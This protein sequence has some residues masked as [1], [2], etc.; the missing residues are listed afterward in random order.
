M[1]SLSAVLLLAY[2]FWG[3][4]AV[5]V[6][7]LT[8][9][10]KF[11]H[12]SCTTV[13]Y[14]T[15]SLRTFGLLDF[16]RF[17]LHIQLLLAFSL[18]LVLLC[19]WEVLL[20]WLMFLWWIHYTIFWS[21]FSFFL[22]HIILSHTLMKRS[23]YQMMNCLTSLEKFWKR[24]CV[25]FQLPHQ[26]LLLLRKALIWNW[27]RMKSRIH[28]VVQSISSIILLRYGTST[29]PKDIPKHTILSTSL[30]DEKKSSLNEMILSQ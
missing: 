17:L 23:R 11:R 24:S 22:G 12:I 5:D 16:F 29:S 14:L 21:Y 2:V 26:L 15:D 4:C 10:A 27:Q 30:I 9:T 28:F 18:L 3:G 19:S 1:S 25:V 20:S 13:L 8:A 6:I 7:F